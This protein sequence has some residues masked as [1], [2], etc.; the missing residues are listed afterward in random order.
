MKQLLFF[1]ADRDLIPV[2]QA[3]ESR[4][5][6]KYVLVGYFDTEDLQTFPQGAELPNL[7]KATSESAVNNESF[8]VSHPELPIGMRRVHGLGNI[9]RFSVDQLANPDSVILTPGGM[10]NQDVLLYG[11]VAT[12]SQTEVAQDLMR[13]FASAIRKQFIKINAFYVGPKAR[14]LFDAGKRLTIA[15]QSP[16][17]FDLKASDGTAREE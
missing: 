6:L 3:V 14:E 16:R 15:A 12:V 8:L 9:D 5:P 7:G 1:A 10:W 13:R 11:R 17:D 4:G 2:L